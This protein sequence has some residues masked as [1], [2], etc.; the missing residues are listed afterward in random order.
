ML[1]ARDLSPEKPDKD[2]QTPLFW[3]MENE[4]K[5]VIALLQPLE[6]VAP[7][8][9]IRAKDH[10]PLTASNFDNPCAIPAWTATTPQHAHHHYYP[11]LSPYPSSGSANSYFVLLPVPPFLREFAFNRTAS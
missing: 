3:A 10:C 1:L 4:H 7:Q 8:P 6:S 5:G 11:L 9:V 2:C